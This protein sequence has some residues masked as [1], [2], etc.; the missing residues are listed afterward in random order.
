MTTKP[1][2]PKHTELIECSC[3][4]CATNAAKIGKT[5]P[6]AALVSPELVTGMTPA[7]TRKAV[8]GLVWTAHHPMLGA[9]Q[10][11]ATPID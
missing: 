6:L 11:V 2:H 4:E 10:M 1:R 3:S 7:K 5:L 9:A 8:H